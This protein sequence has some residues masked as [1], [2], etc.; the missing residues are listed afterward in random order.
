MSKK[1]G[2]VVTL[3]TVFLS[4]SEADSELHF[5]IEPE[6]L[7]TH[8]PRLGTN[9]G[10]WVAWG[11]SQFP[12]NVL[13]NPGFEGII[14]R[15]IVIVKNADARGFSD[16][17]AWTQRPD[18]FWAGAHYDVRSGAGTGTEGVL[19][20][21]LSV[22]KQGLPEF[23]V[24]GKAPVLAPGDVVSLTR[25]NDND[26]PSQWWLAKD[27]L[28]GQMTV[29]GNDKR[30]GSSGVRALAL[31]PLPEKPAEIQSYL[32]GIS[33][34]AGKL[35]PVNSAWKLRFWMRQ[36][37]PGAKLV[38][39]FRRLNGSQPFYQETFQP[40]AQWQVFERRFN[41]RDNGTPGTL[42]LSLRSEG[43]SG[44][45]VLDDIELGPVSEPDTGA[46]RPELVAALKQLQPGYLRDWQGQLGDTFENR[47]ADAFARRATRYRPGDES[48]FSYSLGE[49]LQL[50]QTVGSQP[51]IIIPPTM[52]DKEL[53][54]LGRYLSEQIQV[55]HFQEVLVEFGNEN[56]NP[57][58]R[59]AGIPDYRAHGQVATRAFQHLMIGAN[60]H[61]AIRTLVNGQYVNPWL[62]TKY[63]DGVSNADALAV[64]PYFLFKLDAGDNVLNA[65]FDQDDFYRET[66]AATQA[67]GNELMVYEVNLHTT[68]GNAPAALRNIAT[69]SSAAG[70]ALAKRLL[71]GLNLGIKR[72][73]LYTLAQYDAFVEQAQGTH[74]LVKLWG[75]MR[76][77]GA[78]QRLRPSGLIMAMLN[79]VLPADIHNVKSLSSEDKAITLS[80]FHSP[81]GWAIAV[82]SA[83]DH[84]QKITFHFPAQQQKQSWRLLRLDSPSP[85]ADNEA[86]ENVRISDTPL[87]P[88]N[89][90]ISLTLPA[91]GF[92]V[93]LAD[94]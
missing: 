11:A 60:H 32:D 36:S 13:K 35:L 1:I 55:F 49:F 68:S 94:D 24:T 37:A 31:K 29:V 38:V 5:Q 16:D 69:S 4:A 10:D 39:R 89:E 86:D 83:K 57:V 19:F 74:E 7:T 26:L 85:T 72:Q 21:S 78:T 33:D 64:A 42:E 77:L 41:A 46:F 87:I 73:C 25:I 66:L 75:L 14:D 71:I 61:P 2:A 51:W 45:I 30:P 80:A 50:A 27:L 56:W 18:G 88:E 52:G 40:T 82:V 70:A 92:V 76:D 81:K 93:A 28:P 58:F 90:H 53:Q 3:C 79:R 34:R 20:D 47:T 44:G 22:G 63:L 48:T 84:P 8:A 6:P 59:P 23:V 54:D 65:L 12:R 43:D 91:Y 17:T 9:L 62:S 67:R 15:A